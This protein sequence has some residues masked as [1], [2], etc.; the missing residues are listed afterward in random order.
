MVMEIKVIGKEQVDKKTSGQ[1]DKLT[2][3]SRE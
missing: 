3:D 2:V 1:V